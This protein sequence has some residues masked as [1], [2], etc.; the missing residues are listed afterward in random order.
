MDWLADL[1]RGAGASFTAA[2]KST[3]LVACSFAAWEARVFEEVSAKTDFPRLEEEVLAF[4]EKE[5]VFQKSIELRRGRRDYIFY[6]GPPFATGLPHYGHLLA[7]TI[8]DIIPRY[9]TMRG[10]HVP[11]RF[12]WDCHGLPIENEAAKDLKDRENLDL[13]GKYEIERYGVDRFNEYCRSIVLKYT[14]EWETVV[15][16]MG[17]WVDFVR[18]YKTMDAAYMESIWWVFRQLWDKGLVYKGYRVMPFSWKLSTP[19]SNFEAN[20]NYQQVQDP[21]IVVRFALES[22]ATTFLLAWTTTPWTLPSNLALAVGPDHSYVRVESGEANRSYILAADRLDA[23]RALLKADLK[24]LET[25]PASRLLGLRYRPLLPFFAE[26]GKHGAFRVIASDHVSREEGTG[27]VHMAPAFGEDD[28]HACAREG[29]PLVDPVDMEGRFTEQVSAW[30]G[31]NV[32]AAD[33]EI[34]RTLKNQGSLVHQTVIEHAY[35]FCWRSN[36][37]LIYKAIST[38]FVRVEDLK[39]RMI[40]HNRTV[41]WVPEAIGSNRFGNWLE[42]A[43]DW[44]ISRNRY[45]GTPIPVWEGLDSG[46]RVALGSVAELEALCGQRVTDL[47]AHFIDKLEFEIAG[48]IYRRIPE[49]FDCWFES[50]AMP[51]AQSHYPFENKEAFEQGF[52]AHFIAEGLDQTRGWF[53]TLMV[54][55]TALFDKPAFRNVVVNGLILAED[56][57]KMSKQK[58]N[59]PDPMQV[60]Q[61]H[62]ADCLRAYLVSSP[63]VRAEPLRFQ[64][65][66]IVQVYR[67][68]VSPLWNAY[69]FFTTYARLDG[70]QPQGCLS[71]SPQPLDRWI[72]SSFQSLVASVNRHMEGNHLY[73]VVPELEH[74]IDLLTNWYIRR[75]RKRF[76]RAEDDQ[77]K[78]HAYNTL[79]YLLRDLSRVLAPFM[80]FLCEAMYRNL[81]LSVDGGQPSS[82]HLCNY[83]DAEESLVDRELERQMALARRVVE[84]GRSLRARNDLK[85]RQPLAAMSVV[86]P[87]EDRAVL[88]AL[89]AIVLDELNVKELHL[90]DA[91]TELITYAARPNLKRLGPKLGKAMGA[92]GEAVRHL[93]HGQIAALLQSGHLVL[94][95]HELE[96]ADFLIDRQE[97]PGMVVASDEGITIGLDTALTP[98]LL[99]EGDAREL[100]NRIQNLRKES[101]FRVEDRIALR[102]SGAGIEQLLQ[103]HRGDIARETLCESL[104]GP[105]FQAESQQEWEIHGK[106]VQVALSRMNR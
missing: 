87:D 79:Y 47:H 52:P 41:H 99:L 74:F 17:R 95:G 31:L 71:G 11:R 64:E 42:N 77:D 93:S 91:E 39:D 25:L 18:D 85:I 81:V 3:T 101:G 86:V 102:L 20:M 90:L 5:G 61:R 106:S 55:S 62:G 105:A 83:P 24:V 50:G 21:A 6:D 75:S 14:R 68:V 63:A 27:I 66:G 2:G 96:L 9:W 29:L 59:Y 57:Q 51:Y 19:L 104:N 73:L 48:E 65:E 4:W 30:A 34:I 94:A 45:W 69:S 16:R 37:P 35:P 53:Y 98:E 13:S 84:L 22:D 15:K 8:K 58:K 26:Q 97:R 100:I 82:V 33:R 40:E 89:S 12:G 49:V 103:K 88:R 44:N 80:P 38:W 72:L 43:R 56:G 78:R 67:N 28:F 46:K 32:K 10:Y 23:L 76:W 36:T 70:Y 7:G 1:R 60:V 92:V 54:L